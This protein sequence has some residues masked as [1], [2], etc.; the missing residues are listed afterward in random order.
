MH[1]MKQQRQ[2]S[3]GRKSKLIHPNPRFEPTIPIREKHYMHL[4]LW[5]L[6]TFWQKDICWARGRTNIDKNETNPRI[7]RKLH[8]PNT[9]ASGCCFRQMLRNKS[10]HHLPCTSRHSLCPWW[11]ICFEKNESK[12]SCYCTTLQGVYYSSHTAIKLHNGAEHTKNDY[13]KADMT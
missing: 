10:S 2:L 5:P 13:V 6:P 9:T 7:P 11:I 8:R 4:S 1:T 3:N 12:V